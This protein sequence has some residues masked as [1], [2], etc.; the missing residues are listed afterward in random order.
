MR[1]Q[2]DLPRSP[3]L[4]LLGLLIPLLA[5]GLIVVLVGLMN[6][7][8]RRRSLTAERRYPSPL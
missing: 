4:L 6:L 3:L 7:A 2:L 8:S 5:A 1:H